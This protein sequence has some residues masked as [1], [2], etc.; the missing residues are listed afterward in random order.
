MW[1]V[2]VR[3]AVQTIISWCVGVRVLFRAYGAEVG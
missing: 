1:S 3:T 2:V